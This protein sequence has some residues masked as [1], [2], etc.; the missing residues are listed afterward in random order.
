MPTPHTR[1]QEQNPTRH[2]QAGIGVAS[3]NDVQTPPIIPPSPGSDRF[4]ILPHVLLADS[5]VVV[6]R[7]RR[8]GRT[9]KCESFRSEKA[10]DYADW[11]Y[12]LSNEVDMFLGKLIVF[13]MP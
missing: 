5:L 2:I 6:M 1:A 12:P 3:P 13:E 8:D 9:M 10:D 7:E 4:R 11:L